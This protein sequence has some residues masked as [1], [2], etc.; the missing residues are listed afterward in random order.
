MFARIV[1]RSLPL[2]GTD[3]TTSCHTSLLGVSIHRMSNTNRLYVRG[4]FFGIALASFLFL[5]TQPAQAASWKGLE[6]FISKR[7]DVERV[8][9]RHT[10]MLQDGALQFNGQDGL[11]SVYFVTPKFVASKKLSPELEGTVLQIIIQHQSGAADTPESLNLVK[12][13]SFKRSEDK[14]VSV[15]TNTKDGI[16]YTF[17]DSRLKTT[18][19]FYSVEQVSRLQKGK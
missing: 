6:P 7:A 4:A 19:Y 15:F 11:V 18:R 1:T 17:V 12:N 14:G 5:L 2:H 16:S 8:L 9:G 13:S 10:K 3:F